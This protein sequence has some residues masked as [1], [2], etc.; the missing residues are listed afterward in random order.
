MGIHGILHRLWNSGFSKLA[1]SA[2]E[3][4]SEIVCFKNGLKNVS[5]GPASSASEFLAVVLFISSFYE[6]ATENMA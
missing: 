5:I 6:P 1:Y 4:T 3:C 2:T